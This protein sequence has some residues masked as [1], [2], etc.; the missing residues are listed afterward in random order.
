MDLKTLALIVGANVIAL[1][2]G[3]QRLDT[4]GLVRL[5]NFV[6][7]QIL[8]QPCGLAR[9]DFFAIISDRVVLATEVVY[10]AVLVENGFIVKVV[11]FHDSLEVPE[12]VKL[13]KREAAALHRD[14]KNI[15]DYGHAVVSPGLVDMHVH[16]D[17]PGREHWEGIAAATS[18]AA[19][20]GVT[21]LFD[22]PL[23]SNPPTT[24]LHSLKKKQALVKRKAKVDVAIWAGL[25]PE[26]AHDPA[27]LQGLLDQGALGFK[28][29]MSPAGIDGFSNVNRTHIEA[30]LPVLKRNGVPYLVHAEI[31][32]DD[33]EPQGDPRKY[34]TYLATR[35]KSFEA[36]AVALLIDV[37]RKS[38]DQVMKP[39]FWLHI[40]HLANADLLQD[41]KQAQDE[42][43]PLSVETAPHYIGFNDQDIADGN[44]LLKCAPPIRDKANQEGLFQG[45]KDGVIGGLA[46][47]HSPSPC[48]DK[49]L[50]EG[51][52]LK[53]WGGISGLQYVLPATW[54]A[55]KKLD[56]EAD[57]ESSLLRLAS[58]WSLQPSQTTGLRYSKGQIAK[59]FH[60]DLVV[61]DPDSLADT[62]VGFMQHKNPC[63]P[64][65][66]LPLYG[67]VLATF[68]EGQ[69]VFDS[70]LGMSKNTCGKLI[71]RQ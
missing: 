66:S 63:S 39:G 16:M 21:T 70:Q 23:N 41:I 11:Q 53:A 59:G 60:A 18:A 26:N 44:S 33:T 50:D 68:V 52:F 67:K 24:D 6:P 42:G 9:D 13:L 62:S 12:R 10:G 8:G 29:F 22:M 48:A 46:S 58:W 30:A 45:L 5:D 49:L 20:G 37:L 14:L 47:D 34:Q 71:S 69:M 61:W 64:Y 36:N 38:K 54:T 1:A 65:T 32:G 2:V 56:P 3:L 35:P 31:V 43:L 25:V 28:S 15:Y 7:Y 57:T 27:L 51:N 4:Q 19:T 40:V 17:E 55:V